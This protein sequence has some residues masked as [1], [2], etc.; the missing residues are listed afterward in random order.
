VE[1]DHDHEFTEVLL[2]LRRA[3]EDFSIAQSGFIT[4]F[5]PL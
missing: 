2:D 4:E 5:E 1:L 3:I